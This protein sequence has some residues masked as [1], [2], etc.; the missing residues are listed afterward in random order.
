MSNSEK[1]G[2]VDTILKTCLYYLVD[3]DFAKES[4]FVGKIINTRCDMNDRLQSEGFFAAASIDDLGRPVLIFNIEQSMK[5]LACAIAHEAIH[6]AQI[7]KGDWEPF[8]GYSDWKGKKY[9]NLDASDPNYH[10]A[11]HQPWEA[12]VYEH[13][14]KLIS[15]LFE[16]LPALHRL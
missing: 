9:Q 12:E 16:N 7:C 15:Y 4:D 5:E 10:S 14:E 11:E 6:I 2:A 8:Q 3:I 13:E 1:K